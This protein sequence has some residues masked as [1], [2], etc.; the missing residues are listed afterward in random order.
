MKRATALFTAA[1]LTAACSTPLH[2][3]EGY[4]H[5]T[6]DH[7]AASPGVPSPAA[8]SRDDTP[9]QDLGLEQA[10]SLALERNNGVEAARAA[11]EA[12]RARISEARAAFLPVITGRVART[13]NRESTEITIPGVTSFTVSPTYVTNAQATLSLSLF[14]FWRDTAAMKAAWADLDAEILNERSAKQELV[15]EVTQA[16]YRVHEARSGV[17]VAEDTEA[18]ARRQM[19]DARNFLDAGTVTRD[20]FLTAKVNWLSSR[21]DLRVA[22]NA[23]LHAKRVLNVLLARSIDAPLDVAQ[24]PGFE[25]VVLDTDHLQALAHRHNAALLALRTR[26]SGLRH[27]RESLARSW[28]PELFGELGADYTD[29]RG[30]TGFANNYTA[31]VA[32]EWTPVDAGRRIGDLQEVHAELVRLSETEIQAVRDLDLEIAK[33]V[34]DIDEQEW[35]VE[36]AQESIEAATANY[37]VIAN[38]FRLGKATSREVLEAQVTL[39]DSRN[40]YNQARFAHRVLIAS[41]ELLVG[42]P[43]D[44]WLTGVGEE[45]PPGEG[46]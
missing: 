15:F 4:R 41:L 46:R 21:Q 17:D 36:L 39:S 29:F 5:R 35:A 33:A 27:R 6:Y 28:M 40:R 12:A 38:R 24:S 14:S 45:A 8:P 1:L 11:V 3:E 20:A 37:E 18:A 10:R 44:Y 19:E 26:R 25:R 2:L 9:L 22:R 13:A 34:Q 30:S 7:P 16:W 42:V 31:T 43:P 23:L 32:V